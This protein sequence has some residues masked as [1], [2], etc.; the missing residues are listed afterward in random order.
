MEQVEAS[1]PGGTKTHSGIDGGRSQGGLSGPT[2]S[3]ETERSEDLGEA[4]VMTRLDDT[5]G[6]S[7]LDGAAEMSIQG[8]TKVTED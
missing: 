7:G 8:G 1:N 5:K 4:E 6:S 2:T 3:N